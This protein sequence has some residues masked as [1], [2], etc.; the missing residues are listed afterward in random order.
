MAPKLNKKQFCCL[1]IVVLA[2]V[3]SGCCAWW[4][5][6]KKQEE[7]YIEVPQTAYIDAVD[8]RPGYSNSSFLSRPQYRPRQDKRFT[9][10]GIT[11]DLRGA[12][13]SEEVS[14]LGENPEEFTNMVEEINIAKNSHGFTEE[15]LNS[16]TQAG[17]EDPLLWTEQALPGINTMTSPFENYGENP[18]DPNIYTYDRLI[19]ANQRRRNLEGADFIR[20][21]LKILPDNRNWFQVSARPHLD[22]RNGAIEAGLIGG[23]YNEEDLRSFRAKVNYGDDHI[24]ADY[25]MSL[26]NNKSGSDV[27]VVRLN[28][29][30]REPVTHYKPIPVTSFN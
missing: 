27:E 15:Q 18:A 14:A 26:G 19:Y 9:R 8:K 25:T 12:M 13:P 3:V 11:A 5:W 29:E 17:L 22:L 24:G 21:D 23:V 7:K 1:A 4:C 28:S 20:G 16:R 2:L 30:E 6:C 10:D